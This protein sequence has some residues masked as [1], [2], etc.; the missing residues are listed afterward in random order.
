MKTTL[1]I[2][3]AVLLATS[4]GCNAKVESGTDS[5]KVEAELPKIEVNKMPDLNP[6]TD[7]DV[8]IKTPASD[9]K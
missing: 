6:K 4:P 5:V 2:L 7:D 1:A 3:I 9:G 8:D